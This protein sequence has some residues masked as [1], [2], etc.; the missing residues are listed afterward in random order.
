MRERESDMNVELNGFLWG[1]LG[2]GA[3]A[4][5]FRTVEKALIDVRI[6]ESIEARQKVQKYAKPFWLACNDLEWRLHHILEKLATGGNL[7]PLRWSPDDST[8]VR[9]YVEEGY[10]VASTA[11]LVAS[12]AAW[13]RLFQRDV[14]FLRFGKDSTTAE[15]FRLVESLKAGLSKDPP[16]ILWY[17]YFNGIGEY[18]IENDVP[19][20]IAAFTN[21]L[22]ADRG[23]L[24]YYGQLFRFLHRLAGK[25]HEALLKSTLTTLRDIKLC[26]E[27]NGA[28]PGISAAEA[29][30]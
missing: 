25:D 22:A 19:M 5:V 1:A 24:A 3:V 10:Y 15:F 16:S 9:W 26:L 21:K 23:Y 17:H 20:S 13:I 28:V 6:A 4:L 2:G 27:K 8:P 7:E 12:V 30:S 14:V 18:L 11:Y 29:P